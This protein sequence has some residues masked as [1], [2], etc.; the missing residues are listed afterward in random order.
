MTNPP[1]R[2]SRPIK[3]ITEPAKPPKP[4]ASARP[5]GAVRPQR[6]SL[7]QAS[8]GA[9]EIEKQLALRDVM[10]YAV[11]VTRAVQ[12]AKQMESYRG[13]PMLLA[14]IAIP[15]L[16]VALYA[17]AARPA[18]VF[19]PDPAR[20]EPARQQAYTRF[21]MY[22]AAQRVEEYRVA[23]GV[24]PGSLSETGEEW[25]GMSYRPLDATTFELSAPGG[26]GEIVFR[27]DQPVTA[28]LG[29]SVSYLRTPER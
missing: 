2:P 12:L 26:A 4:D 3:A 29:R 1:N 27:S 9:D 11:R 6:P 22:L 28:F 17:Y 15:A 10:E 14:L 25:A 20:L 19:G 7:A 21:A 18:W 5:T 8:F 16:V 13:R 24:L 23:R